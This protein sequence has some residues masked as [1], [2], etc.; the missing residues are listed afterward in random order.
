MQLRLVFLSLLLLLT[1]CGRVSET[2]GGAGPGSHGD[3]LADGPRLLTAEEAIDLA[4]YRGWHD[5]TVGVIA[6]VPNPTEVLVSR[7]PWSE[8]R[9]LLRRVDPSGLQ[10]SEYVPPARKDQPKS[11][12]PSTEVFFVVVRGPVLSD[13]GKV[14]ADS[15]AMVVDRHAFVAYLA[16]GRPWDRVT[17]PGAQAMPLTTAHKLQD[18]SLARAQNEIGGVPLVEPKK[19]PEGMALTQINVNPPGARVDPTSATFD[20]TS[21]TF[22]YRD[23]THRARVWI[24]QTVFLYKPHVRTQAT[25]VAIGNASG[26]R[27]AMQQDGRQLIAF[28]WERGDRSLY[29]AGEVGTDLREDAL[30]DMAASIV[31]DGPRPAVPIAASPS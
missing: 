23:Q 18:V 8:A 30:V 10:R 7:L 16:I 24:S 20:F 17:P 1:A 25:S 9:A 31:V 4:R 6:G 29:L 27:Y 28:A 3:E 15:V 11:L 12:E 5:P 22:I 21:V 26:E 13:Q 14:V 19:L 2:A